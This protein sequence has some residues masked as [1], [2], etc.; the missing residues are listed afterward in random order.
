MG[1]TAITALEF[2]RMSIRLWPP[3][4]FVTGPES[5]NFKTMHALGE[6]MSRVDQRQIDLLEESDPRTTS[7]LLPEWEAQYGLTDSSGTDDERRARLQTRILSLFNFS[8]R[9]V[10]Y[11]NVLA[12]VLDLAPVD[13]RVIEITAA[14]AQAANN[15]RLVYQFYIYRDPGLA[16][17]PQLQSAQDTVDRIKHS[18]T[19]GT[20]IES[21]NFLTDDPESLTDRDILG[22]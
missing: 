18:N 1:M 19:R 5:V 12:P 16:G 14:Q 8:A 9:P 10:D 7:E 11:Q 15:P 4:Q 21:V 13:V 6:E 17:T 20:V 3:G 2:A 22:A